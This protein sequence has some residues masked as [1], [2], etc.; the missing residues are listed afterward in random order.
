MSDCDAVPGAE[1]VRMG[2]LGAGGASS[3]VEESEGEGEWASGGE[4]K[5]TGRADGVPG[6]VRMPGCELV[7]SE[8]MSVRL[9]EA[10][11]AGGVSSPTLPPAAGWATCGWNSGSSAGMLSWPTAW[12]ISISG[13]ILGVSDCDAG[14]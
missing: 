9:R 11:A 14:A 8:S 5:L 3:Q 13:F 6:I 12:S 7:P 4:A 2:P 1:M 10:E